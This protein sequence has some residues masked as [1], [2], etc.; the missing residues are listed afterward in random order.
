MFNKNAIVKAI[1]AHG[2][3]KNR[4]HEAIA[5]GQSAFRVAQVRVDNVCD[6]GQWLQTLSLTEKQSP[7][8]Q[9]VQALHVQFHREAAQVLELAL[10]GHQAEA[11]HA[12]ARGGNFAKVSAQLT[13]AMTK[14]LE[15]V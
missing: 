11:E 12:M 14:W 6:F 15:S 10:R 8:Y 4:L 1:A 7:H 13:L 5:T 9:T 2:Q 3:W